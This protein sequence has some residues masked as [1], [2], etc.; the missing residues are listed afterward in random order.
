MFDENNNPNQAK[1]KSFYHDYESFYKAYYEIVLGYL[2]KRVDSF[3]DAEDITGKVF[4][5]CYEK[6]NTY[7]PTKASQS[8][9]LFVIV[10]SR[11]IDF[12]RMKQSF[13]D[14]NEMDERLSAEEDQIE[15]AIRL[16]TI[17][18][19][20]AVALKSL[21]KKQMKAIIMRYFGNYDDDF[22][23]RQLGTTS[24]NIRVMIHRGLNK[25]KSEVTFRELL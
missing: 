8:T 16:E 23:A 9:W 15:N 14:I 22:I 17:R 6:W 11:W 18:Q 21:P 12:L 13:A 3:A 20:L 4:L 10:R 19:A 2:R 24:G 7:D 25:L 1:Q 5:Y